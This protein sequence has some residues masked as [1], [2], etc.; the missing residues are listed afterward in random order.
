MRA[1]FDTALSKHPRLRQFMQ[2][3][4]GDKTFRFFALSMLSAGIGFALVYLLTL[5]GVGKWRAN[6][7]VSKA[8]A[9]LGLILNTLALTGKWRPTRAQLAKWAAWWVPSAL[10]GAACTGLVVTNFELG[11]LECRLVAG[12]MMFPVD[13]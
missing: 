2:R 10:A 7:S 4:M 11:S 1:R 13:Y 3:L 5:K 6:E 8:M 9:P 12:A